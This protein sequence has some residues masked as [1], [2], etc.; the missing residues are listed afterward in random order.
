MVSES[1]TPTVSQCLHSFTSSPTVAIFSYRKYSGIL[2]A[3]ICIS[4]DV[5]IFSCDYLVL[6]CIL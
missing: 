1:H 4:K 3:L 6:V 5:S 2:G